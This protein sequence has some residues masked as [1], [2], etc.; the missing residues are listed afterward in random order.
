MPTV[1]GIKVHIIPT[2]NYNNQTLNL[3]FK[4]SFFCLLTA[5]KNIC[6]IAIVFSTEP[7]IQIVTSYF[8]IYFFKLVLIF[9]INEVSQ[10]CLR[11]FHSFES[12]TK[13]IGDKLSWIFFCQIH[14]EERREMSQTSMPW[15]KESFRLPW[16]HT[17]IS[18]SAAFRKHAIFQMPVLHN[19][20]TFWSLSND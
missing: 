20:T 1:I 5:R 2:L 7:R 6:N 8:Y 12:T 14:M 15:E 17:F 18:A 4:R 9:G 11:Y 19:W 10:N 3:R 13:L 16:I